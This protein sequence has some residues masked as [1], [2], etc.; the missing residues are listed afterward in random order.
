MGHRRRTHRRRRARGDDMSQLHIA[1]GF[2]LP[3]DAMTEA[4]ALLSTRGRGKTHTATVFAEEVLKQ[5]HQ[6]VIVDPVGLYW[7]LRSSADGKGEGYQILVLGGS[8]GDLP[9]QTS[10]AETI[11]RFVVEEELSVVID[12]S[13]FPSK[14]QQV[15]FCEVFFDK[16]WH[17]KQAHRSPLLLILEEA[18]EFA[19]QRPQRNEA[20]ML[21]R[22]ERLAKL[23]RNYGIGLLMITQRPASLN[24]D[25][26]DL[27][28]I[29]I[30]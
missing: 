28:G 6:V 21:S 25:C 15:Q 27:V 23:G 3:V 9:L 17:L 30:L 12:L 4:I 20:V 5:R 7:G 10:D 11:A 26:L 24:K 18:Q 1:D 16:L 13:A 2:G 29:L 14:S 19:P 8:H 22:V